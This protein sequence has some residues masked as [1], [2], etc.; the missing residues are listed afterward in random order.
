MRAAKAKASRPAV[1]GLL[2]QDNVSLP[3]ASSVPARGRDETLFN[4]N[5]SPVRRAG[6]R[7]RQNKSRPLTLPGKISSLPLKTPE[8]MRASE[9]V[10]RGEARGVP[11]T[12][13][14]G[15]EYWS[16]NIVIA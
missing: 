11:V 10:L 13:R 1:T 15:A 6:R 4:W 14:A 9:D 5:V 7:H 3:V 8:R 16:H 12:R 2:A